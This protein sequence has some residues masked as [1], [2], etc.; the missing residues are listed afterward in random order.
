MKILGKDI[1]MFIFQATWV[2]K[3]RRVKY[4][5]AVVSFTPN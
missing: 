1:R 4:Y 5:A 3:A 2:Q